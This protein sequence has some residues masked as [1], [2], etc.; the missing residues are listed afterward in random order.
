MLSN[1]ILTSSNVHIGTP[2]LPTSPFERIWSESYP[3]WVGRSNAID[4]PVTPFERRY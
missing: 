2:T 3:V 1:K 4:K